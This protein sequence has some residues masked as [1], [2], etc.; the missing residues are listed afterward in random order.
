VWIRSHLLASNLLSYLIIMNQESIGLFKSF[1]RESKIYRDQT[2][3]WFHD[4]EP[5][6]HPLLARAFDRWVSRAENGR[7]CLKNE[8]DWVYVTIEGAPLFVRSVRIDPSG[9]VDLLLS[10]DSAETL[11]PTTL[12]QDRDGALYCGARGATMTAKFDRHVVGQLASLIGE[13]HDGVFIQFGDRRVRPPIV[14]DPLSTLS[15]P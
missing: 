2:G 10:D 12:R 7:Y 3:Q 6:T 8:K 9:G 1:S 15:R 5:V 11:D 14:D 4:G 13:D